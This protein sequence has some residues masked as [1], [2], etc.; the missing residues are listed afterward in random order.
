LLAA[1]IVVIW[2]FKPTRDGKLRYPK[3]FERY[4]AHIAPLAVV[5]LLAIALPLIFFGA[6]GQGMLSSTSQ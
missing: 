3:K 6:P 5:F 2:Y 4:V 1:A